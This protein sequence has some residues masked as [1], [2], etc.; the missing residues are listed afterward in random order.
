M[1]GQ[2]SD[3]INRSRFELWEWCSEMNVDAEEVE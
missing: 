3:W 2:A 1:S